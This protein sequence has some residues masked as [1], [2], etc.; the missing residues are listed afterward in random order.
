M[1][2]DKRYCLDANAFIEPW[3]KYFTI[4]RCPEYWDILNDLGKK[5]IVFCPDQVKRE[6]DKTDDGLKAWLS[7]RDFFL[8]QETEIVQQHVRTVL[9]AFP[10]L[11]NIGANRSMADPWV[12][13]HAMA[14]QAV[15]VSKEYLMRP[16]QKSSQIKIPDVCNHFNVTC[17]TDFNFIDELGIK[18]K[19]SI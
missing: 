13:A 4:G 5:Q 11:I 10:Q 18:F 7:S 12:I 19:A 17:I 8:R 14:E 3:N 1:N 6:I 16:G 15:V 9:K 2:S